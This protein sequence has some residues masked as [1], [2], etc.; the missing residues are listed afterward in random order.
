[1]DEHAAIGPQPAGGDGDPAPYLAHLEKINDIYLDQIKLA[2]QKAAFIITFLLAFLISSAEGSSVFS[3]KRYESGNL[4]LMVLSAI[5]AIAVAY[6]MVSAI[7]VVL[8]RRSGKSTSLYWGGWAANRDAFLSAHQQRDPKYLFAEYLNSVDN[9]A[10][11]NISK[12]RYVGHAFRGL[13]VA[14]LAY[15]LILTVGST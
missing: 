10:V 15:L 9:L 11:I 13:T 8:P 12:Y 2:D 3:M 7:L 6:A 5:L 14:V 4:P 1:M